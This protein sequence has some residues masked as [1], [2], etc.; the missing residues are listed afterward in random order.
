VY[1]TEVA[2]GALLVV[3]R[4]AA[5][6]ARSGGDQ[7]QDA[8]LLLERHGERVDAALGE[9]AHPTELRGLVRDAGDGAHQLR[10]V[11]G[12][13]LENVEHHDAGSLRC[14]EAISAR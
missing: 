4:R 9:Q 14:N 7:R 10:E 13:G 12:V 2:Q 8:G 3:L 5:R 11:E 1:R 6:A